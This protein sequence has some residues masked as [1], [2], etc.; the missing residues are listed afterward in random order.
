MSTVLTKDLLDQHKRAISMLRATIVK[1]NAE[2]WTS[3]ISWFQSPAK[4]AYH[5]VECL[6]AYFRED[7]D[8]AYTWG[9]RFGAPFWE[10]SD[11]EQ[12]SQEALLAYLDDLE[13]GIERVF[14]ALT[15]A[16]LAYPPD[17]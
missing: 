8:A 12:P 3:G 9:H 5:V 10:L 1:F 16:D 4:V 15:D 14:S 2:Q 11:E 17:A 6:D 7:P 13:H